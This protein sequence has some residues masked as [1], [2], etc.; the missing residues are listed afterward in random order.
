MSTVSL[1]FPFD[2]KNVKPNFSFSSKSS[3]KKYKVTFFSSVEYAC[4]TYLKEFQLENPEY[5][6]YDYTF[7]TNAATTTDLPDGETTINVIVFTNKINHAK[8]Y[9]DFYLNLGHHPA[10]TSSPHRVKPSLAIED[11]EETP[12]QT[13]T[14]G[15][16]SNFPGGYL[17]RAVIGC[18]RGPL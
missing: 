16:P 1:K 12:K 13:I 2:I 7:H 11:E 4:S 8:K 3:Q 9:I 14:R 6:D 5:K 18:T 17:G 10:Q 15:D